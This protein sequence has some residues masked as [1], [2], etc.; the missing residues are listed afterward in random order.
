MI[1][2][3]IVVDDEKPSREALTKYIKDFCADVEVVAS[4]NSVKT[5]YSAIQKY[6]PHLVLLDIEMPEKNGFDLLQMFDDI[7]FKV[8][9]ITAYAEYAI[10]AFRFSATDYL[11]KPVMID[12]LVTAVNRVRMEISRE[13]GNIN[14][15]KLIENLAHRG[16][17]FKQL[18]ISNSS[19]FKVIETNEIILCEADAYCTHFL[20]AGNEKITSSKNLKHYEELLSSQGFI[21]VHNSYM[22][23]L[24]HVKSYS[25][26]GEI[27]LTRNLSC[28]LGNAF[29]QRFLERFRKWR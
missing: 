23:N 28:P 2:K 10:K 26:Q 12:E 20:L 22:V 4:C 19:G 24:K 15:Q 25:N 17:H 13:T 9:F 6:H 27:L 8:V 11:L 14:L 3:T 7:S 5:A 18:V 21:R 16:D 29:K 1:L